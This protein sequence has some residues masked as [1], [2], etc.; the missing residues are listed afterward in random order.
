MTLRNAS[1]L[2]LIGTVVLTA[3]LVWDLIFNVLNVLRGIAPALIVLSSLIYA[4]AAFSAA[5]FFFAFHRTQG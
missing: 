1:L 5:V 4:F 3:L 2:G